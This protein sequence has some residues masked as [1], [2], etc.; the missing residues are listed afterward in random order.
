MELEEYVAWH[1]GQRIV[2]RQRGTAGKG[3]LQ[4]SPTGLIMVVLPLLVAVC[5]VA[6]AGVITSM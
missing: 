6:L 4:S 5:W 3:W 1:G 2:G